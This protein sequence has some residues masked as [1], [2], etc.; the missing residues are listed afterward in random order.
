MNL[1]G[2]IKK[3]VDVV[4]NCTNKIFSLIYLF[5]NLSYFL[6][7]SHILDFSLKLCIHLYMVHVIFSSFS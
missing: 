1:N 2:D 4:F 5:Q 3:L 7:S 6:N